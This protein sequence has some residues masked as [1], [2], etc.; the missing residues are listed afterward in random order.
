MIN[1][2]NSTTENAINRTKKKYKEIFP[3]NAGYEFV[4]IMN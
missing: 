3:K 1:K 2:T 4:K